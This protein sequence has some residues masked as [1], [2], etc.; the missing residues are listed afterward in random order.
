MRRPWT[1]TQCID[2]A[3]QLTHHGKQSVKAMAVLR[4]GSTK[5][6]TRLVAMT[7]ET[8][9]QKAESRVRHEIARATRGRARVPY[10]PRHV[11]TVFDSRHEKVI[12]AVVKI[13][14]DLLSEGGCATV[15]RTRKKPPRQLGAILENWTHWNA[16]TEKMCECEYL[17][18]WSGG[19]VKE[20]N[21][22]GKL[23]VFTTWAA[24]KT[25]SNTDCP[26]ATG[27]RRMAKQARVPPEML[28]LTH[29]V[30]E[31]E[32][33]AR[34]MTAEQLEKLVRTVARKDEESRTGKRCQDRTRNNKSPDKEM[35]EQALA[36]AERTC[37]RSGIHHG[38]ARRWVARTRCH[39]TKMDKKGWDLRIACPALYCMETIAT[40]KETHERIRPDA[41]EA[42]AE[43][44]NNRAMIEKLMNRIEWPSRLQDMTTT[45]PGQEKEMVNPTTGSLQRWTKTESKDAV[46]K[47]TAPWRTADSKAR[48][49]A[50]GKAPGEKLRLIISYDRHRERRG[51][52][53]GPR[54][55]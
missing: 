48:T 45:N 38:A 34:R 9:G 51:S 28:H 32:E 55:E 16:A 26:A 43:N 25:R 50:K 6:L 11:V 42:Q 10:I 2:L 24:L 21:R 27:L 23:H 35:I 1:L 40:L 47:T 37:Q 15:I 52:S 14:G 41:S 12:D 20:V 22:E 17:R 33:T 19:C 5:D 49:T 46:D 30:H 36:E 54:P 3:I 53:T 29:P 4:R 31:D 13:T 8:M 18:S 7:A 44:E 39:I